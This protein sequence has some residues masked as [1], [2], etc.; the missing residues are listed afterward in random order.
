LHIL[1]F[2]TG[3]RAEEAGMVLKTQQT[4]SMYSSYTLMQHVQFC[5]S[6]LTLEYVALLS[7]VANATLKEYFMFLIWFTFWL[8]AEKHWL[9]WMQ[10]PICWACLF[11]LSKH[12]LKLTTLV[13]LHLLTWL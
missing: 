5:L 11:F 3:N 7:C 2:F 1:L 12:A 4:N 6:V 10:W 8:T 9:I 13:Q